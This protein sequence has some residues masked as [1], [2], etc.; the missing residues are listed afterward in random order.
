MDQALPTMH[1]PTGRL[2]LSELEKWDALKKKED[3]G[4]RGEFRTDVEKT[5][6]QTTGELGHRI[7]DSFFLRAYYLL[8]FVL[9]VL[10]CS[11]YLFR[12][13]LVFCFTIFNESLGYDLFAYAFY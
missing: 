1:V 11:I 2:S 4:S 13:K 10:S 12:F 6:N 9:N 7:R 3:S 5:A 8:R